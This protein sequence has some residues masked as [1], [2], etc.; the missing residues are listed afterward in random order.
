M[1]IVNP[2]N[3]LLLS[4][5]SILYVV[6]RR[7]MARHALPLPPGPKGIPI[8]GNVNDMPKPGML[9][10]HHW[11]QHKDLYGPISSVK[12]L[13]QTFVIINDP[14]IAFELL[15]DRSAIHSSRPSQIFSG[16]MVG[17]QY[18]TAIIPYTEAWKIHRKNITKIASTNAS[19]AIFDRAQEAESAHFLLNLLDTPDKLFDHIRHEAGSVILKITYGYNTAPHG[20][21]PFVD[22][23][24]DTMAQFATATVPGR[25]MVDVLPFCFKRTARAMAAQLNKCTNQPYAFVKR[26][27]G[28]KRHTPSFLSQC[29]D[30]IGADPEMEFVHKWAALALYL[31]GADTTVSSIMTF[32]LA[33]TVFPEVQKK[34]QEE[35]DRVI[36]GERL[37]VS[38]D[39]ESLPYI[40]A[41]MKET[42]RWH[43]VVPMG[44][45]HSSTEEDTC[46][47]YRI[48]KGAILLPNN[49]HFTHDP[50][51]Y[52]EPMKF[53]PERYFDTPTHKAEPDPRNH[54]FGYGRRICPGRYVADNALFVTIAQTLAVFNIKKF[55][56][57]NGHVVEPELRF[58]AGTVSHP[59]PYRC[60]IKPRSAAHEELIRAAQ[61][62]YPLEESHAKEL[63]DIEW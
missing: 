34:A 18:A 22:L 62:T 20:H 40:D 39:R 16:Q 60:S 11:L 32:F 30:D 33:M 46:R 54:I 2:T 21:D 19:I 50:A 52:S 53:K 51:V 9:E 56:D 27:M 48:P 37:P 12:V 58:E 49:W 57:G 23:A 26:Q 36:S 3:V 24:A 44:I 7:F 45:P 5:A 6:Y 42:H 1:I 41:V 47:G 17:W 29:I 31:G 43:L 59:V 8:L 14:T 13:G 25:W 15:R 38:K 35:L 28:E 4:V 10:C 63:E 61:Q 55:V